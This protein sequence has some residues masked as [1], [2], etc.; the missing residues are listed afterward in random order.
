[1]PAANKRGHP[2]TATSHRR[3]SVGLTVTGRG[4]ESEFP[5]AFCLLPSA[6]LDNYKIG[7]SIGF[8]LD[9]EEA[10]EADIQSFL[11]HV[12]DKEPGQT[13]KYCSFSSAILIKGKGGAKK[14]TKN[15]KIIKVSVS[16]LRQLEV[17]PP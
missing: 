1:V 5:S 2:A 11:E 15:N 6:F 10:A 14:F 4:Q 17:L 16:A 7:D 9:S 13:S 3:S 12:L 8:K